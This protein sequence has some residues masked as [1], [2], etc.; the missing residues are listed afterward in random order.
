LLENG[1]EGRKPLFFFLIPVFC[2]NFGIFQTS[3]PAVA[4][5]AITAHAFVRQKCGPEPKTGDDVDSAKISRIQVR[6]CAPK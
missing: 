1:G 5:P 3:I 6:R 4:T 2:F